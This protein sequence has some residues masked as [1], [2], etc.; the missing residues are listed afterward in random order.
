[1][2]QKQLNWV[3]YEM[4]PRDIERRFSASCRKSRKNIFGKAQMGCFIAPAPYS[5]DIAL[6][7]LTIGCSEGYSQAGHRLMVF[8]NYL[9]AGKQ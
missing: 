1:M 2:I 7:D 9:R 4:K 6:S 8:E 3:L 5:P